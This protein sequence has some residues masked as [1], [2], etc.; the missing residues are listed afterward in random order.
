MRLWRNCTKIGDFREQ[1]KVLT[2]RLLEKGYFAEVLEQRVLEVEQLDRSQLLAERPAAADG[3]NNFAWPFIAGYSNQHFPI[4]KLVRKHWHLIKNDT[5]LGSFL[6]EWPQ[7]VFRGVPSL[8]DSLAPGACDP[9]TTKPMFFQNLVAYHKC[10]RCAVCSINHIRDRKTT[11]FVSNST[12]QEFDIKSFITCS[13]THV[14]Y[15]LICPCELQYIGRTVQPPQVILNEHIGNI[16]R[17]VKGHS[18]S[19]HYL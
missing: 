16:R 10:K 18:V 15:L 6:P 8:K 4:K 14:V 19:G 3:Q 11:K 17:G 2:D 12:S 1:A 13:T 9:P 5:V 7:L